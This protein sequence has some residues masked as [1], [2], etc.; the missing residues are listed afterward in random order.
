M[1]PITNAALRWAGDDVYV[2][3]GDP[4]L[5]PHESGQ[6]IACLTDALAAA[7]LAATDGLPVTQIHGALLQLDKYRAFYAEP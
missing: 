3:A 2:T 6:P 5:G 7:W 4:V 1:I